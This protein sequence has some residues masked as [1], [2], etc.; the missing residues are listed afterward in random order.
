MFYDTLG[1][2]VECV[3][4]VGHDFGPESDEIL[5]TVRQVDGQLLRILNAIELLDDRINVML[6]SDHGMAERIGGRSDG[7]SGLIN[8]L[9]YVSDTDWDHVPG[10]TDPVLQIWPKEGKLESV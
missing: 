9:D 7:Q 1:V 6:F 8:I 4:A 5:D 2:Y 10:S 3:D